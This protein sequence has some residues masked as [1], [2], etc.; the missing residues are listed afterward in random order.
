[1]PDAPEET[2]EATPLRRAARWAL[3]GFALLLVLAAILG[4]SALVVYTA[5]V[6]DLRGGFF[7]LAFAV[8]S[9][10]MSFNWLLWRSGAQDP[11]VHPL[12]GERIFPE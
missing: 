12:S 7:A 3:L 9:C 4:S 1:M 10:K 8:M 6:H 5:W 11:G 2:R